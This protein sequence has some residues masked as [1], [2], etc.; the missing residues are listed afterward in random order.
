MPRWGRKGNPCGPEPV[1]EGHRVSLVVDPTK[2]WGEG[3][4]LGLL[5]WP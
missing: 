1:H 5:N 4:I 3:V 2:P